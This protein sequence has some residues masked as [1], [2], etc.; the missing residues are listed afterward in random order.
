[1][2]YKL[3]FSFTIGIF[4]IQT[5]HA[6]KSEGQFSI[7]IEGQALLLGE[8]NA[9]FDF[10]LGA[11]SYYFLSP[12]RKFSPFISAGLATDA[13][14]TN[15]RLISTDVQ[16][17]AN[18]NAQRRC[19]LLMSLGANYINESHA[20]SLIEQ[21]VTWNNNLLG[22]TGNL[23]VNVRITPSTCATVFLKQINLNYTSIGLGVNYSL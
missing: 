8:L 4:S 7:G 22:I 10:L 6:Q 13:S 18:W 3:L 14:N 1:M 16:L 5:V 19:S 9:S 15:S 11:K 21:E 20:H 23:G 2:V 17:G 12:G